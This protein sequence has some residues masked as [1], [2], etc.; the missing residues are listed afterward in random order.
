MYAAAQ[1][2]FEPHRD[3][4]GAQS[5]RF[6]RGTDR[7]SLG[8]PHQSRGKGDRFRQ[9]TNRSPAARTSRVHSTLREE[10]AGRY[11]GGD[12]IDA[13]ETD[14]RGSLWP[15]HLKPQADELLSS[16]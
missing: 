7:R 15:V 10:V 12:M 13:G 14:L 4:A 9:R 16:W 6:E 5:P 1:Q 3:D 2:T 8:H 11:E